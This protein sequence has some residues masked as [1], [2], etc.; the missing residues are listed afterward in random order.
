LENNI[1]LIR[2]PMISCDAANVCPVCLN[3]ISDQKEYMAS[4]SNCYITGWGASVQRDAS[5]V[6]QE[7]RVRILSPDECVQRFVA[8]GLA[9]VQLPVSAFC[10]EG[11]RD[12]SIASELTGPAPIISTCSGDGG[13]PLV[14]E[15]FDGR[16]R[17]MGM[18]AMGLDDCKQTRISAPTVFV[19]VGV[20]VEWIRDILNRRPSVGNLADLAA[21]VQA[22]G[23]Q[24]TTNQIEEAKQGDRNGRKPKIVENSA[25]NS[26]PR[27]THRSPTLSPVPSRSV[28][29]RSG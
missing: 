20:Y 26:A 14:C 29:G 1:A 6:L 12:W 25:A 8:L 22:S 27:T 10:A 23:Q 24:D 13:G 2:I 5:P 9:D 4:L 17:L 19:N 21:A 16:W 3:D 7:A 15:G 28:F 11:I 18:I